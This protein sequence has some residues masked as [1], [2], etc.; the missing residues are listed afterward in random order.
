[1][2][3]SLGGGGDMGEPFLFPVTKFS[4]SVVTSNLYLLSMGVSR[5]LAGHVIPHTSFCRKLP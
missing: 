1:M 5:V 4:V 3:V 2:Y